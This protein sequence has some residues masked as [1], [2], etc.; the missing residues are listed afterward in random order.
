M[1][2][3]EKAKARMV[4]MTFGRLVD[5]A[6]SKVPEWVGRIG[7]LS[8]VKHPRTICCTC[9]ENRSSLLN[10]PGDVLETQLKLLL[11]GQSIHTSRN[12]ARIGAFVCTINASRSKHTPKARS[13]APAAN[14]SPM[15]GEHKCPS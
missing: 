5:E 2:K 14:A 6:D 8:E 1:P 4:D 11:Q 7:A 12:T 15:A 10:I 3:H 9:A 13:Q